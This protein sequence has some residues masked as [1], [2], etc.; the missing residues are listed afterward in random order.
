MVYQRTT[1]PVGVVRH[2]DESFA[3]ISQAIV[4]PSLTLILPLLRYVCGRILDFSGQLPG[5]E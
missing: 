2:R 5:L 4:T 1:W 3:A